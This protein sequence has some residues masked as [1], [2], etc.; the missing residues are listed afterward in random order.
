MDSGHLSSGEGF[1]AI[2]AAKLALSGMEPEGIIEKLDQMKEHVHTSF[3]VDSMEYLARQGQVGSG[4]AGITRSL[5]I[6]PVIALKNGKMK[7]GR[8]YFG[9]RQRAWRRYISSVFRVHG[10]IDKKVLFITYVGLDSLELKRI[11]EMT[12]ERMD[13]EKIYFQCASPAIAVNCGPGTFG[14]LFTTEF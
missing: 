7:L 3:I 8:L 6:R 10:K 5:L 9:A 2:Q 1:I 12:R 14:L 13:F 11:E 4:V